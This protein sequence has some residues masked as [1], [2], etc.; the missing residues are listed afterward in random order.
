M[1]RAI[2]ILFFSIQ[3]DKCPRKVNRDIIETMVQAYGRIFGTRKPV[4]DGRNNMYT[5]DPVIQHFT[6]KYSLDMKSDHS[7]SRPF[8]D[9]ISNGQVFEGSC[10]CYSPSHSK[11]DHSKSGHFCLYFKWF[12]TK[13]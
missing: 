5:R 3:P 9:Q 11:L 8:E 4:F 10:N 1:K 13:C 2:L 12:L 6:D 7:K